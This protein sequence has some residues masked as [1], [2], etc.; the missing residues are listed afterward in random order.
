MCAYDLKRS[1]CGSSVR[2]TAFDFICISFF[3]VSHQLFK[4]SHFFTFL[5]FIFCWSLSCYPA[6][7]RSIGVVECV[8]NIGNI[9][10][11]CIRSSLLLRNAHICSGSISFSY[12][13]NYIV[14]QTIFVA[15]G[16][17]FWTNF[18]NVALGMGAMFEDNKNSWCKFPQHLILFD[19]KVYRF[20]RN[21]I[22]W[23]VFFLW[24]GYA[25]RHLLYVI[26]SITIRVWWKRSRSHRLPNVERGKETDFIVYISPPQSNWPCRFTFILMNVR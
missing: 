1:E 11:I 2:W 22:R 3:Y 10:N 21:I 7:R 4:F 23:L 13:C 24:F 14:A 15:T 16:I 19:P 17:I 5:Y 26:F 20:Q 8:M 6:Q 18:Y 25:I 9:V 12:F